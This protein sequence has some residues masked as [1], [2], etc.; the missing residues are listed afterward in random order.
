MLAV[1]SFSEVCSIPW[2]RIVSILREAGLIDKENTWI[3]ETTTLVQTGD[4]LDRGSRVRE[5]MDLLMSLQEQA[6]RKGGRVVVLLGNH[7]VFNLMG[8]LVDASPE[9][10]A[11]FSDAQSEPRQER[12][13]ADYERWSKQHEALLEAAEIPVES[14]ADWLLHHPPGLWEYMDAIGPS[15]GWQR[16]R[17]DHTPYNANY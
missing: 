11:A 3:G 14:E 17:G 2:V 7:E 12:A 6:T 9:A 4:F 8:D 1:L 5:V 16:P 15:D 10:F 13:H